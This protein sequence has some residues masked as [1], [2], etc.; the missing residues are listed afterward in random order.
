VHA[1]SEDKSDDVKDSF[2]GEI[3]HVFH[4]FPRYD[5]KILMSDFNAKIGTEDIFK[6]KI[7]NES[8]QEIS[9]DFGVRVINTAAFINLVVRSTMF[10]HHRIHRHSTRLIMF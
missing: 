6:P 7:G 4:Q 10:P 5:M 8:P 1:Q 9:N 3:E 2:Y